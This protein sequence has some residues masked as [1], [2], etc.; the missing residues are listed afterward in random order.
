[1]DEEWLNF[2]CL[3]FFSGPALNLARLEI[4]QRFFQ[5]QVAE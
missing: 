4:T 5:Q 2:S 1:M 3:I